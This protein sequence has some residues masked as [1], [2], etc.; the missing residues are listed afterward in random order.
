MKMGDNNVIE[1]KGKLCP[2]SS[3]VRVIPSF[4][5]LSPGKQPKCKQ[6]GM[7]GLDQSHCQV[8][9]LPGKNLT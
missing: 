4:L 5:I 9:P 7:L 2:G 1:S 3:G 6:G 8:N